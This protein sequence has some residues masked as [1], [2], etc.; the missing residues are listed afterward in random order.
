MDILGIGKKISQFKLVLSLKSLWGKLYD[1]QRG[2]RIVMSDK[3]IEVKPAMKSK[4]NITAILGGIAAILKL[5]ANVEVPA[6]LLEQS[7]A[8]IL[9]GT[10]VVTIVLRTWY[11]TKLTPSSAAKVK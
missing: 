1:P 5:V 11:T 7:E 4:I 10:S 6:D 8:L 2:A 3:V 9:L